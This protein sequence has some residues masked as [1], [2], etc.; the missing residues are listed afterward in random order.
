MD[1]AGADEPFAD[2]VVDAAGRAE[3]ERGGTAADP[4]GGDAP[5][6]PFH[7]EITDPAEPSDDAR[8]HPL[9]P[10]LVD[11]EEPFRTAGGEKSGKGETVPDRTQLPLL[12]PEDGF[13]RQ[14]QRAAGGDHRAAG[15]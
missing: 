3:E 9:H 12:L 2:G 5:Q 7:Q 8:R 4:V 10:E 1:R 14:F 15:R 11:P 13:R 6:R